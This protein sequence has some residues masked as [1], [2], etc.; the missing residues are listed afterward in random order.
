MARKNYVAIG[1]SEGNPQHKVF[2][3]EMKVDDRVV[4]VTD[5]F[6]WAIG[7]ITGEFERAKLPEGSR[8][9]EFQKEV[10]WYKVAKLSYSNFEK[11]LRNKLG[12]NRTINELNSE[13][14]ESIVARI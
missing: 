1:W 13:Q 14:W 4:V 2:R 11:S 9:Y 3:D 12:A 5:G 6:I 7:A 10:V 8:L